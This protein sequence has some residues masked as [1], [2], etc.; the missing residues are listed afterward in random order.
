M[1]QFSS[2]R[3]P[4]GLALLLWLSS[5]GAVSADERAIDFENDIIPILTAGGCNSGPC[6]GKSRGQGGFKLSLFGFDPD[7]D[8][9]ALSR[10]GRGRRVFL[11]SPEQSLLL[12]KPSGRVPH[13]GGQRLPADGP[14]YQLFKR[15]VE[16]GMNRRAPG[17][18]KLERV[19]V[20]PSEKLMG[21]N[22][23]QQLTVTAHYSDGSSRD[24]TSLAAYRSNED[25]I[26]SADDSGLVTTTKITGEAAI[27]ARYVGMIG[28]ST[29]S[30]PL[31]GDVPSSLY[32]QLPRS[33]FID[34]LVWKKLQRL[35]L[36]PSDPASDGTFLRR[37]TPDIIG[38][39]PTADEVRA[40]IADDSADK[41]AKLIDRL[42]EH[43]EYADHWA[44]KWADLVRPNPYR[45]GIKAVLNY[46]NWIRTAFRENRPYNQFVY[47][48]LTATGSTFRN[49]AVVMFRD[50]RSPDELTTMTTQLFLGIRLEC[51][52]CHQ[53]PNESWSQNH[54]YSFAAYFDGIGRKGRG[55]SPP[56]SGSEEYVFAG[57]RKG[58]KHPLTGAVMAA[59]PLFGEAPVSEAD[60]DP[61]TVLADWITSDEN[62]FFRQV[63]ANRVWRDMMGRGLVEPVDDLR[64]SNPPSNPELLEALAVD[65]RDHGYD[66][67]HL[68]RRI[69][70]SYV[71]GLSSLP[72]DRNK[73]D[74]RNYSRFYRERM[75]AEVLLDSVS[76]ITGVPE[77][78]AAMPPGSTSRQLWSHRITSL[79]LDAFGRPDPNQDPPCERTPDTTIVQAL[80]LMNSQSVYNKVTSDAGVAAALGTGELSNEDVIDDLYL[81][82]YARFPT[83]DEKS[84]TAGF[85]T[86]NA[87]E[88]RKAVQDLMW[89]MLNTPEFIF[90]H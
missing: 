89:A 2:H 44:N 86:E 78:F 57:K 76:Q 37:V 79:F 84:A 34:D 87:D 80:H 10:E 77:T 9:G 41:R 11:L 65:F 22:K 56:I 62:P 26:A 17:A 50:R 4:C 23:Q 85:L 59:T 73:S 42:L 48:Q 71:Y 58:V 21:L 52:K 75:R 60:D 8:H 24:V 16:T 35:G 64:A 40:F 83:D 63:M 33:N 46:D 53:H 88:R 7:F 32:E 31:P 5:G 39:V 13:G 18:P 1:L 67:K 27:M 19:T 47:E 36:T 74:T 43:P 29:I 70:S 90:K 55:V 51:A 15:W 38:R 66:L 25:G 68:I 69:A 20:D 45:A 6:H 14:D 61:R 81:S 82:I 12:L 30:V 28:V 3:L 72:G 49:G 54:F